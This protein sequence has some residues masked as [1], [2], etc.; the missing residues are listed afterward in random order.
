ME[1][2]NQQIPDFN[3]YLAYIF[4]SLKSV[5][6]ETRQ[7]A[8]II[9]KNNLKTLAPKMNPQALKHITQLIIQALSD[10]TSFIRNT[11]GSNITSLITTMGLERLPGLLQ[12]LLQMTTSQQQTAVEGAMAALLKIC[13]DN[14]TQ[15]DSEKLGRPLNVLIPKLIS[16]FSHPNENVRRCAVS[17]VVSFLGDMP[18]AI[19]VNM[20]SLLQGIFKLA[21]D[22]NKRIKREVCK[23]FVSLL[24]RPE[25]LK[26]YMKNIFEY[27]L[28]CTQDTDEQLALE[29]CEFWSALTDLEGCKEYFSLL[30]QFLPRFVNFF[31]N[32]NIVQITSSI[33]EIYG[34]FRN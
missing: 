7:L 23:A 18:N 22:K 8:G 2:Y 33:I 14:A 31:Y 30:K 24:E 25:Y 17:A 6:G 11:A 3:N 34:L 32:F 13:E 19:L 5:K 29:A 26:P 27:M 1:E 28:H 10:E 15:L 21:N 16:F 20:E 9:L 4:A 12:A